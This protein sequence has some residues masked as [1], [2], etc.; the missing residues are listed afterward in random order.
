MVAVDLAGGDSEDEVLPVG[1]VGFGLKAIEA[2]EDKAGAEGGAFV[3][4]DEG[5]IAAE[6]KKIG[7]GDFREVGIGRLASDGGLGGGDGRFEQGE[8]AQA[9]G[10][11]ETRNGLGVDFTDDF[12]GEVEAVRGRGVHAS[13]FMVRA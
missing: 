12:D 2:E 3:T 8:I 11:A 4:V 9:I 1:A 13:F 6:V 5:V 10:S 7:G